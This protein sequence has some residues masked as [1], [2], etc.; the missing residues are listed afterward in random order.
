MDEVG[1]VPNLERRGAV[2]R[3]RMRCPQHLIRDGMPAEKSI[4]L[5]TKERS[6]ALER[7]PAARLELMEFF[8]GRT[9]AAPATHGIVASVKSLRRPDHPDLPLLSSQQA[10]TLAKQYFSSAWAALDLTCADDIELSV[11]QREQRQIELEDRLVRLTEADEDS[12]DLALPVEI[13]LLREAGLRSPYSSDPSRLLR[14][15]L[16]RALR[17]LWKVELDRLRGDYSDRVTDSLFEQN[18]F[19]HPA[20]GSPQQPKAGVTLGDAA[21]RYC[22]ELVAKVR[23]EKTQDRYRAE[24]AHIVAFFGREKAMDEFKR[25]DCTAFRDAF[26]VLP[27]NFAKRAPGGVHEILTARHPGDPVLAHATLAKYLDALARFTR[28]AHKEDLIDK[29]YGEGLEPLSA[30]P[31]GS[32]AKLPFETAEL[33]RF[34]SRP[35]YTGCVDDEYGFAKEGANIVRR[36]RYWAPLIGLFGG[37]R[38][39]EIFQLTPDHFRVSETG[40]PFIVLTKDMVLKNENA[41]RE[42]PVHPVLQSVGLLAWVDRRRREPNSL[43]FPEIRPDKYGS[44][45]SVFGKRFRSDLKHLELGERRAKLT[46]HSFRHTFKRALDREDIGEQEKDELCGWARAKKIGRRYGVGLEADRLK[47]PLESVTYNLDLS[48]LY[49]HAAMN[50]EMRR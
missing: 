48:H 49:A 5:R 41:E 45:S 2:Y 44:V 8:Q 1:Q 31:D 39:G 42:I 12:E 46:F 14:S 35:I 32:M 28:W 16:R 47:H 3:C 20:R 18:P 26:A 36:A 10:V 22:G 7:L 13:A 43:L 11:D 40:T 34:F 21:D 25:A 9:R 19:V 23:N 50:D 24:V 6:V 37:L 17:Q 33:R 30:K 27:P 4:S 29:D 38:S 15:Y